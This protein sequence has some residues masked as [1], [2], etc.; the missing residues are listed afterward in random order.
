MLIRMR[1]DG[2]DVICLFSMIPFGRGNGLKCFSY[3]TLLS[4]R[5]GGGHDRLFAAQLFA[6]RIPPGRTLGRYPRL[7]GLLMTTGYSD[8]K[9]PKNN[10]FTVGHEKREL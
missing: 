1:F 9:V 8:V 2:H 3:L 4:R 10:P 7:C 6:P 5:M